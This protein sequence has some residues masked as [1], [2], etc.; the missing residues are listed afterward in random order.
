MKVYFVGWT[1]RVSNTSPT[2]VLG[3]KMS[4]GDGS[5]EKIGVTT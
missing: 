2:R 1:R 4:K 5:Y 3:V